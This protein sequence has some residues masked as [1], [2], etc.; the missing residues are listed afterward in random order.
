MMKRLMTSYILKALVAFQGFSAIPF[1][2][3]LIV[4]PSGENLGFTM[5]MLKGSPF[6]SFLIP[7]LFLFLMLG[8]FPLFVFYGLIT[9]KNFG[10]L[11]KFNCYKN[12]HWSWT[13]S[14]FFGLLLVLWINMQLV[15]GIGFHIF[16]FVYS[17][18]GLLIVFLVHLPLVKENYRIY[19]KT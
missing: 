14:H 15:F 7:G 3:L 9:K 8:L 18:L 5:N 10:L 11:E 17:I 4:D 16:H 1:G 6:T 13:F 2:F 19:Q 12:Y